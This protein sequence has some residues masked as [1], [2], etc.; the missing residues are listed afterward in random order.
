[1]SC[2]PGITFRKPSCDAV[3]VDRLPEQGISGLLYVVGD[4]ESAAVYV[5]DGDKFVLISAD[6]PPGPMME[7]FFADS[8]G[9]FAAPEGLAYD[10]VIVDVPTGLVLDGTNTRTVMVRNL[11]GEAL[12]CGTPFVEPA[13]GPLPI[14]YYYI[15]NYEVIPI[16]VT[17]VNGEYYLYFPKIGSPSAFPIWQTQVN[18]TYDNTKGMLRV[19]DGVLPGEQIEIALIHV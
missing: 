2:C 15:R 18:C 16:T 13:K 12:Y 10:E 11:T 1:M 3:H 17:P 7:T 5:W 9:T 8:N 19:N 14:W 4:T 6:C